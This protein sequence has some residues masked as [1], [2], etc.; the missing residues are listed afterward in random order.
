MS[1]FSLLFGKICDECGKLFPRRKLDDHRKRHDA[2]R[3]AW[4]N[5]TAPLPTFTTRP[6]GDTPTSAGDVVAVSP[7]TPQTDSPSTLTA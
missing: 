5:R 7:E 6:I 3:R 4:A 1:L 2:G